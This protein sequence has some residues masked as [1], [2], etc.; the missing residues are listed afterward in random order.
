MND[1][2]RIILSRALTNSGD[3]AWD[4]A[5]PITLALMMPGKLDV[6]AF[7]FFLSRLSHVLFLPSIGN[8]ID[9]ISRLK[10]FRL[11]LSAQFFGVAV[12]GASLIAFPFLGYPSLIGVVVGGILSSLGSAMTS[13]EVAQDLVPTLF[14]GTAL[15]KIN[16]H[17]RQ[18]DLFSEVL[19]PVLA[20]IL[21]TFS[22][23]SFQF[24]GLILIVLWNLISFFP[25]YFLVRRVLK[26]HQAQLHKPNLNL[27]TI[28]LWKNLSKGWRELLKLPI[29]PAIIAYAILWLSVLSPHGVLLT[30][31]LKESWNLPE[32][33]LG[34]FRGL[35][36]IFGLAATFIFPPLVKKLGLLSASK[37]SVIFLASSLMLALYGFHIKNEW[38]F[39][40]F[41]L[42]S[43]VG[44]YS[45]SLGEQQIRQIAV[46]ENLRGSVNA[47]AS[48][49]T[50]IATLGM[51]GLGSLMGSS[52]QFQNLVNISVAFVLLSMLVF[53]LKMRK[54]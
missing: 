32:L 34:I 5:V 26:D 10:I 45:F 7:V 53:I 1:K 20:G 46:P 13:I 28:P 44:V 54:L 39:L 14:S 42:F 23:P 2:K 30:S 33:K 52:D 4:F 16:S 8:L 27:V 3:Q 15:T 51:L 35:G 37:A 47:T 21:L 50:G 31:F 40:G 25:E 11:G 49:M 29:A 24:L 22:P 38:I 9:K 12:Q 36:A 18:V 19:S 17:I 6:V 43:R 41:I 48:A